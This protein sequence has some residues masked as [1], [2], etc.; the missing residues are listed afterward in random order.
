MIEGRE[1]DFSP[2]A[3]D[4]AEGLIQTRFFDTELDAYDL[5]VRPQVFPAAALSERGVMLQTVL[6]M[7][8]PYCVTDP[9]GWQLT[10]EANQEVIRKHAL[11]LRLIARQLIIVKNVEAFVDGREPQPHM[12]AAQEARQDVMAKIVDFLR[13][14]QPSGGDAPEKTTYDKLRKQGSIYSGRDTH[15]DHIMAVLLREAGIGRP[16]SAHY[17]APLNAMIVTPT[18]D[19]TYRLAFRRK[20]NSVFQEEAPGVELITT[21]RYKAL[22]HNQG[23]RVVVTNPAFLEEAVLSG[24]MTNTRFDLV[25]TDNLNHQETSDVETMVHSQQIGPVVINF[26]IG[27]PQQMAETAEGHPA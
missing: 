7:A 21:K 17:P 14:H 18:A 19:D 20:G 10:T 13:T 22:L 23:G 6:D 1:F 9:G 4:L 11:D 3:V 27:F 8:A 12:Q 16:A 15:Q 2:E 5:R 25:L 24:R 26:M